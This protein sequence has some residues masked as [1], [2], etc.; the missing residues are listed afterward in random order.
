[1]SYLKNFH[2]TQLTEGYALE[3]SVHICEVPYFLFVSF[4]TGFLRC[5][6]ELV[7][8]KDG[9]KNGSCVICFAI[10]IFSRNF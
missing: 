7:Y 9:G 5:L 2:L 4:L 10:Q 6:G 3:T 8:A 1:M